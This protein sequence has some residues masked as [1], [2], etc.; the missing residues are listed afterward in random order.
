[1]MQ[2]VTEINL[3][4]V[5]A[6]A[7]GELRGDEFSQ[8]LDWL[9][10]AEEARQTWHTYHLVGDVL[11]ASQAVDSSKDAAFLAR[12]K[13]KLSQETT[14]QPAMN[15]SYLIAND[16]DKTGARSQFDV[17]TESANDRN[18]RWKLLAG[19]ASLATVSVM[20]WQAMTGLADHG[21]A[22]QLASGQ[23]VQPELALTQ[24]ATGES[25]VMIRDPQLDALMA[26]HRQFGGTSALQ[27]PAG[28]LRNATFEGA[29]R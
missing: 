27:M 6:L 9:G 1:M 14:A 21:G 4:K 16:E 8:T 15:A 3:E 13:Q 2:Q 12:F 26:A 24:V 19:V 20:A 29:A 10:Q 17:K 11:R 22:P 28:F 18:F 5:S 23:T 7:D 25:T